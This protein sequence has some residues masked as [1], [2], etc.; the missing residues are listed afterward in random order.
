MTPTSSTSP[1]TFRLQIPAPT[2]K[3]VGVSGYLWRD[4]ANTTT[5]TLLGLGITD[6]TYTAS[7]TLSANEQ[8]FVSGTQVT[9]TDGILTLTIS[10]TGASGN[11]WVDAVS[12]PQAAAIDF[13]EFNY[14]SGGLPTQLMTATYVSAADVWNTL[15]SNAN[16]TGSMGEELNN[17]NTKTENIQ[18]GTNSRSIPA[19]TSYVI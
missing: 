16:L 6:S 11:L 17:I 10:T 12:A 2:G 1:L 8:F 13:G 3:K 18:K 5:V 19:S 4:T 7:G 14:W 15:A 9:G